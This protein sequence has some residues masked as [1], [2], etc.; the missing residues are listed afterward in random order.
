MLTP[1]WIDAFGAAVTLA[2]RE[3]SATSLQTEATAEALNPTV[4]DW[5]NAVSGALTFLAAVAAGLF[6][7]RAAHWTKEQA[8]AADDQVTV[9]HAALALAQQEAQDARDEAAHQRSEARRATLRLEEARIDATMPT[10]TVLTS[11]PLWPPVEPSIVGGDA[12]PLPVG[13]ASPVLHMP[14]DADRR[15][16]VRMPVTIRNDS[17]QHV[18]IMPGGFLDS[19]SLTLGNRPTEIPPGQSVFGQVEANRSLGEWAEIYH[20]RIDGDPGA[21]HVATIVYLGQGDTSANDTWTIMLGGTPVE[22]V[23]KLDGVWRII[24]EVHRGDGGIAAMGGGARPRERIYFL[25]KS[26]NERL[27]DI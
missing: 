24:E 16:A 17:Q 4:T 9:A 18:A 8:K 25:S 6:A 20:A 19:N 12:N 27:D 7:W 1:D 23:P 11:E 15:I 10:I 13:T 26:R 21:E 3:V 22:P 2:V 5:I 14:R